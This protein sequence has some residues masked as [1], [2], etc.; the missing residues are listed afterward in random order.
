MASHI[1]NKAIQLREEALKKLNPGGFFKALFGGANKVSL[2][3]LA[4]SVSLINSN[5]ILT[6]YL[7][8]IHA[9]HVFT[10]TP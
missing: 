1:E 6:T 7:K 9:S 3:L 2:E 5:N 4:A 10:S 8:K